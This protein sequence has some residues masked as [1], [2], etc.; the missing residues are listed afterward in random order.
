MIKAFFVMFVALL[1]L[2]VPAMAVVEVANYNND[3]DDHG[4]SGAIWTTN[5]DCGNETQD[6]N[7]YLAGDV[8]YISG[9]KIDS[10][11][12]DWKI[13]KPDGSG[14]VADGALV[15]NSSEE[16]C[17]AAYTVQTQD[18]GV[19]KAAVENNCQEDEEDKDSIGIDSLSSNRDNN[20]NDEDE[21]NETKKSDN[22]HVDEAPIVPEFSLIMGG[23]TIAGALAAFMLIRKK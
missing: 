21:C 9:K 16:F 11:N 12:Y 17:F 3:N 6:E 8:V 14:Q 2:A 13:T 10:G 23:L 15:V 7:H 4:N 22:Y 20:S 5:S 1:L 19:Y 18:S